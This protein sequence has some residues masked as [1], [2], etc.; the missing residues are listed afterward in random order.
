[1]SKS[2]FIAM[3]FENSFDEYF[4][5]ILVPAIKETGLI[6]IRSDRIYG[7]GIIINDIFEKI[8]DSALVI[9]D[10][11]G[12]NPNVNYELGAAHALE[13]PTIIITQSINDVPFDYKHL[14]VIE[15]KR[16]KVDWADKLKKDLIKTIRVIL[17]N[18]KKSLVWTREKNLSKITNEEVAKYQISY[19][20][21]PSIASL[22]INDH[23]LILSARAGDVHEGFIIFAREI[24][25]DIEAL[26]S[27]VTDKEFI[28]LRGIYHDDKHGSLTIYI[29]L[30]HD[31]AVHPSLSE[32]EIK[33]A[34]H[35]GYGWY[36]G[37][38]VNV[39]AE[40]HEANIYSDG[41]FPNSEVYYERIRKS[42]KSGI[43]RKSSAELEK[44]KK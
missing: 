35:D 42:I 10:V 22:K 19:T 7:V 14:R 5:K 23:F 30:I 38:S 33:E 2:C 40:V 37:Q 6:P 26:K 36:Q 1:M 20:I 21:D 12:K 4:E 3:P 44:E 9:A 39:D 25:E 17:G 16:E 41:F 11:T 18:P 32:D 43:D 28:K 24:L 31:K 15:Y 34:L 29:D 27:K 8:S 13:K